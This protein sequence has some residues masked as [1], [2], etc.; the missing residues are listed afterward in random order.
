MTSYDPLYDPATDGP[1]FVGPVDSELRSARR[2]LDETASANIHD[3]TA[4]VKA[5]V[6][7]DYRLRS[8]V[9][10]LDTERGE[11]P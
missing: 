5:A 10:A 3:H 4:M 1:S 8:I 2:L 9:A 7:L 6:S 11:C